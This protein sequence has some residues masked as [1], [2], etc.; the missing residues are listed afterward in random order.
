MKIG[1]IIGSLREGRKGESVGRWV[2]EQA[3]AREGTTEFELIDLKS[4]GVPLLEWEKVPGGAKKQYPYDSVLAWSAAVDACDGFVLV[5]P[6][7]NHSVP[8]GLKNATDWLYPEWQGKAAGLVGYGSEGGVRA[9]EHWRL[10]LANYSTVVVRQQVSLSTMEEFD[11]AQV[12][13]NERRPG[14]LGTL[15]DQAEQTVRQQQS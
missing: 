5:T 10:I 8:G 7:Y 11:G 13:P 15:L 2:H 9:I 6:E 14:E 4:F 3:Q 1:I 12:R